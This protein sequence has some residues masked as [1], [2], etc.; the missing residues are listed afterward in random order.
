MKCIVINN[1]G[2]GFADYVEL[3]EGTTVPQLF[4]KQLG[5]DCKPEDYKIR[6]NRSPA[7]M[8]QVLKDG[9]TI[10]ITPTKVHGARA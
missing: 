1:D 8:D 7:T 3:A 10:S 2:G 5:E 6:V 9:D 4:S